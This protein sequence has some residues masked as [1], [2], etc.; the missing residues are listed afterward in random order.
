MPK[1]VTEALSYEQTGDKKPVVGQGMQQLLQVDLSIRNRDM[2]P[3]DK[4]IQPGFQSQNEH[5]EGEGMRKSNQQ[6]L[7]QL[8]MATVSA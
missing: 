8:V 2:L 5:Y 1:V 7:V 3:G 4:Y 6:V